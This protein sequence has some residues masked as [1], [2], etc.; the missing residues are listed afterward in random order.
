MENN[1]SMTSFNGMMEKA[2]AREA[3][4]LPASIL[5]P[6]VVNTI[7]DI[8]R[9]LQSLDPNNGFVKDDVQISTKMRASNDQNVEETYEVNATSSSKS[10]RMLLIEGFDLIKKQAELGEK[11]RDTD[12]I[13]VNGRSM[14]PATTH[15]VDK[16]T[17]IDPMIK[18]WTGGTRSGLLITWELADGHTY[19]YDIYEHSLSRS[20][21]DAG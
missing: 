1:Q 12:P 13:L 19:K 14:Y 2:A 17:Y 3:S 6:V 8:K 7:E 21:R 20:K 9:V 5:N 10:K 11:S 16:Y 18:Q 4:K 15:S